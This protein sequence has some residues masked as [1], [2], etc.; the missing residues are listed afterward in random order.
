MKISQKEITPSTKSRRY[1]FWLPRIAILLGLPILLYYGYCWGLWG[2]N[3][4]LFQYLFQCSCPPASEEAR[5]PEYVNVI[6]PACK[7]LESLHSPS[8]RLIY[9][10]TEG[11][12]TTSTYL[13]NFETGEKILFTLPDEG[14]N[15]FLTD[16][17]VFHSFYG[18]DEYILDIKTGVIY[19]IERFAH[20]RSNAYINGELNLE[21]MAEELRWVEDIFLIDNDFIVALASDFRTL[22]EKSFLTGWFDI[23]G[24]DPDA[25]QRFLQQNEIMYHYISDKYPGELASP[26]G[27]FIARAD[28]IYLSATEEKIVDGYSGSATFL[29][30]KYFAVRGWAYDNSGVLYSKS[31]I[32][33]PCLIEGPTISDVPLCIFKI[34]Q[35]L[36]LLKIPEEYLVSTEEP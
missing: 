25:V 1:R 2:R 11:P 8:G 28:G 32:H 29:S 27:R 31:I 26:D 5:Y 10:L 9:V 15:Y 14:S 36:L 24:S 23:P 17:L 19:P 20:G 33:W 16:D 21:L 3:S 18:D 12:G 6:V 4:L 34:P 22:P 13:L 7:Y 30:G 35:P